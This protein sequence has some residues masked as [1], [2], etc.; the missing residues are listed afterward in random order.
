M[1]FA[2]KTVRL[3]RL[4]SCSSRLGWR[5]SCSGLGR[6]RCCGRRSLGRR[7]AGLHW[8]RNTRLN[9][10]GVDYGLGDIDGLGCNHNRSLRPGGGRIQ[11]QSVA[12]V[13]R[14]FRDHRRQFLQDPL[15]DL[16]LLLLELGLGI[17]RRPLQALGLRFRSTSPGTRAPQGSSCRPACVS[18]FLRLSISVFWFCSSR[19]LGSNFLARASKSR[20][21]SLLPAIA[22]CMS[23]T[24]T[25]TPVPA[26]RGSWCGCRGGGTGLG[27]RS[28]R[29]KNEQ[30]Y[31]SERTLHWVYR[32]S[33]NC[34]GNSFDVPVAHNDFI[35]AVPDDREN[36]DCKSATRVALPAGRF[37]GADI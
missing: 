24:P 23:I 26:D 29:D 3:L 35:G 37:G 14:V 1:T 21:P 25:L 2:V 4:G 9:V 36:A 34:S 22:P 33:L 20:C 11:Q 32:D 16:I 15:G 31:A 10:V 17:F 19:R 6:T 18:C 8:R 28:H 12:V 27:Q 30:D 13:G 7:V 5:G